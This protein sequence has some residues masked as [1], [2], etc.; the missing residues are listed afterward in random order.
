MYSKKASFPNNVPQTIEGESGGRHLKQPSRFNFFA[1]MRYASA[2][3]RALQ[4]LGIVACIV[5]G[6]AL[7]SYLS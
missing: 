7:V 6:A 4:I 5:A 1:L 2:K 3:D